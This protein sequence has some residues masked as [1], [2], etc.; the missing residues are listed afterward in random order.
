MTRAKALSNRGSDGSLTVPWHPEP[1][2]A[3]AADAGLL[4]LVVHP[5][6]PGGYARFLVL[7]HAQPGP[8]DA[9]QGGRALIASGS[10]A[11]VPAAMQAAERAAVRLAP[12]SK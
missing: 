10:E 7:R 3:V 6:T 12:R 9:P 1:D 8:G 5:R 11:S 4:R 2:G